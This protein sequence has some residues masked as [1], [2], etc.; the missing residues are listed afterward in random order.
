V[1]PA[2]LTVFPASVGKVH[3]S[4]RYRHREAHPRAGGWRLAP[5]G[6]WIVVAGLGLM[7]SL[8]PKFDPNLLKLQADRLP[9]VREV[10]KLP[11]WYAVVMAGDLGKLAEMRAAIMK[12]AVT[13]DRTDSVLEALDKQEWLKQN[14]TIKPV[15]DLEKLPA[16]LRDHLV[17]EPSAGGESRLYALYIYPKVDLWENGELVRFVEEV[18]ARVPGATGIAPQLLHSTGEIHKAFMLSTVYALV[19]IFILVLLDL[20][21]L[22]QTLLAIS[23]LGLGLPMLLLVM[24]AWHGVGVGG[25]TLEE[26]TG[27]P[28]T[29]NFANFFALPILIGA[30]HEYGV[31]M[32][33]RYREAL[34]DPRRVWRVWDVSDRALLLC[35]IVTSCSFGFMMR[36]EHHGLQSLGWVMAVGTGCIYLAAVVVLRPI[37][38]WRLKKKG[39][40][41]RNGAKAALPQTT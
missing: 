30:G 41:H 2:L 1:L 5:A 22:S 28:G 14:G 38:T 24:W 31:F 37:L 26:W 34:H 35:G 25:R 16:T 6:V 15:L 21:K 33:H 10:R 11:T 3:E 13:I 9:S 39:V 12:G 20:R 7:V 4:R 18:E 8:P 36:A 29:W 17:S 27:I 23:V 32:V 19:L 40:Y